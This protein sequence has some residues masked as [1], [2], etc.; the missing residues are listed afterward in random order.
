MKKVFNMNKQILFIQGGGDG[1]HE[2][3]KALVSSL[4][5]NLGKEYDINYPELQSDESL[6]DFGW[7]QQ[8]GEKLL[9]AEGGAII[10]GH[11]L[12]ASMLL[13]YLSESSVTNN[14]K[15]VFLISTPFWSGD[16]DW[17]KGLRLQ[18]D[19][20]NR[21][22]DKVPLFF[23]HCKD[24]EVAPFSH[25]SHYKQKIN[26]A[27]FRGIETGG[28]QLNNDLTIVAHDIKLL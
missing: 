25:F 28:H 9:K 16:E 10:I 15:G 22:P 5:E 14:I 3:D 12:G 2:A 27:T 26:Q 19:F 20:A 11:S 23:Y 4:Q 1:G 18:E 17:K 7:V 13:K 24:D 6:P 21:L 8:I